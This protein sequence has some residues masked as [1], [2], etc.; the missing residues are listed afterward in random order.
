MWRRVRG[1]EGVRGEQGERV[2]SEEWGEQG[3][4]VSRG[5]GRSGERGSRGEGRAGGR[6]GDGS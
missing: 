3:E 5:R 4:G 6:G 1:G 2:R